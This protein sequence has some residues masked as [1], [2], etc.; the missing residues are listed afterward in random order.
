MYQHDEFCCLIIEGKERK[1]ERTVLP[2]ALI[3]F[4]YMCQRESVR[5][6]VRVYESV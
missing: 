1:K 4:R 3:D 5:V 2:F 6:R